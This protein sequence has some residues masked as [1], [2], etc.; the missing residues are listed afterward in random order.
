MSRPAALVALASLAVHLYANRGYGYFRDELY[1]LACT[2]HLDFGYVD[3]PPLSIAILWMVRAT[4]GDSLTALRLVPALAAALTIWA[5]GLIAA[6]LGGGRFAQLL[7]ALAVAIGPG[8]L[9]IGNFYS[10]N[11]IDLA[12]WAIAVYLFMGAVEHPSRGRWAALGVTLGLGLLNKVSVLWL[13]AGVAAGLVL[14]PS[15]TLLLT[16][17]PWLA[18]T[19]ATLLFVPHVAWQIRHDW[20]T[21]EFVRNATAEKMVAVSPAQFVV[22][23]VMT[24]HPLTVPV[25]VAGL[26]WLLASPERRRWRAVAWIFLAPLAILVISGT[27]RAYYLGPA[28]PIVFAAGGVAIARWTARPG[29]QWMQ[30]AIAIVMIAGGAV[31]APIVLPLLPVERQIAYSRALGVEPRSEERADV[32]ELPQHLADMFGWPELVAA[33]AQVY[34]A[35]P[36][37]DRQKAG[38]FTDNYGRAGAVDFFGPAHGLPHASSGHNSYFLW[39]PGE[40]TG[41][42][43]IVIGGDL[44]DHTP[45]F[46][47]VRPVTTVRC[48][49]CMPYESDVTIY[50]GRG[51][52]KP[53]PIL[54][55]EVKKYI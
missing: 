50:V 3:H 14:T 21:L 54:W 27:A 24:M 2:E 23:Q 53:L 13:G 7:A 8:H 42:V 47:D 20:P 26:W 33:V 48:R 35:L 6:R 22:D 25:T 15:R 46:A 52:K 29:R 45:D 55:P 9:A 38:I 19:I 36:E 10:M 28:Y 11:A 40:A 12:V 1:Y 43:L 44:E 41:E 32:G 30:P 16:A 34:R 4:L 39:G 31:T 49:Y 18:G 17:G 37:R 5:T 51:L